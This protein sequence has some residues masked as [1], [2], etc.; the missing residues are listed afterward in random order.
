MPKKAKLRKRET[1]YH[2]IF[3]FLLPIV[4]TRLIKVTTEINILSS[5][6]TY[7]QIFTHCYTAIWHSWVPNKSG[8]WINGRGGVRKFWINKWE[9]WKNIENLIA[10]VGKI[11]RIQWSWSFLSNYH[12]S[13]PRMNMQVQKVFDFRLAKTV[14]KCSS[15]SQI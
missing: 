12:R 1:L 9:D 4:W 2:Y 10:G 14:L 7:M 8:V 13:R 15:S 3:I 5:V 11:N 6:I